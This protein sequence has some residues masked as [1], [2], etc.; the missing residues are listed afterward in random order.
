MKRAA[1]RQ[2]AG[3]ASD[4]VAHARLRGD[5]RAAMACAMA[6][7]S[8]CAAAPAAAGER[9][10]AGALVSAPA[11]WRSDPEKATAL[12][13]RF[14]ATSH[15]GGVAAV[16]AAEAYVADRPGIALF[17]T[18]ATASVTDPAQ[19]AR[20]ARAA[21]DELRASSVR[22]ALAGGA[23]QEQSWHE[24]VETGS[25]Q[26]VA[27][28]MWS[29]P[30]SRTLETAR[31]VIASD[32]TRIAAVTGECLANDAAD[33]ALV[34]ACHRAL[35]TLDPGVP[36]AS[37]IV[38]TPAPD[39]APQNAAASSRPRAPAR[40]DAGPRVVYPPTSIPQPP[41][42]A[43]RRPVYVGAGLIALALVF[44]W[45]RRQRDRFERDAR[46]RRRAHATPAT[47]ARDDGDDLRAAAAVPLETDEDADDLHAAA[48][49]ERPDEPD[50]R[51][52]DPARD[53]SAD[54]PPPRQDP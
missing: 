22:T 13:Q 25:R 38:V 50:D 44:W 32:G 17:A 18:R 27:T 31:I 6:V 48:R 10:A 45:N 29:D 3:R 7:A 8:L 39:G 12:A 4:V 21:L 51:R 9:E 46:G 24:Q 54:R 33:P 14:A 28:L 37:R 20:L 1:D 43:D 2:R 42:A 36:A 47:G 52:D 16:T 34:T 19:G 11:S 5:R 23:A 35:A 30:T 41:R 15:F 49:G 40:L 53:P 26:V